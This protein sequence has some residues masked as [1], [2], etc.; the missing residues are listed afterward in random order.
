MLLTAKELAMKLDVHITTIRRACRNDDIPYERLGKLYF[1]DLARVRQA[2]RKN[3]VDELAAS[4]GLRATGGDR[5]RRT[6][7]ISPRL[8]KTGASIARKPRGKK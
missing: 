7:T 1:F 6:Q 3:A 5:R 2:M 8:G 4:D